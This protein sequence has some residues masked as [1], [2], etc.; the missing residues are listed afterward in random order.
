MYFLPL[1]F[2]RILLTHLTCSLVYLNLNAQ[3]AVERG[4]LRSVA[5]APDAYIGIAAKAEAVRQHARVSDQLVCLHTRRA[6][7]S[8]LHTTAPLIN[9]AVGVGGDSTVPPSA[10]A[11]DAA[12]DAAAV[13]PPS[14]LQPD[15]FTMLELAAAGTPLADVLR[16]PAAFIA[17]IPAYALVAKGLRGAGLATLGVLVGKCRELLSESA[18]YGSK[19]TCE[20]T[21]SASAAALEVRA[22]AAHGVVVHFVHSE[23]HLGRAGA[24][25]LSAYG[26]ETLTMRL[27]RWRG[28]RQVSSLYLPLT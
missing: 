27:A 3:L 6:A 28:P 10:T 16:G 23:T 4:L 14:V 22:E 15:F 24:V 18:A 25:H 2:A 5:S 20:R 19:F 7:L 8:L 17:A 21:L 9:A 11:G 13:G 1:H 12:G 26:N